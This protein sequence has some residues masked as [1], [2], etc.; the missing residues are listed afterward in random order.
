[1]R[2]LV[3]T[4]IQCAGPSIFGPD[5]GGAVEVLAN[6]RWRQL[7]LT[8]GGWEPLQGTNDAG[9][10]RLVHAPTAV[11]AAM[12]TFIRFVATPEAATAATAAATPQE[13]TAR[14]T[15]AEGPTERAEFVEGTIVANY[16]R[17]TPSSAEGSAPAP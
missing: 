3:A 9:T 8:P 13:W 4:W 15:L 10:W 5:G 1:M 14:V 16:R 17:V 7:A 6:G 2:D 11:N 12:A